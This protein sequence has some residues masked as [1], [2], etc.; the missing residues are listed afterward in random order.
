MRFAPRF[1]ARVQYVGRGSP[2]LDRGFAVGE[3]DRVVK[4]HAHVEAERLEGPAA[5]GGWEMQVLVA[6]AIVTRILISATE[7]DALV[8]VIFG[9]RVNQRGL[10]AIDGPGGDG[11][12]VTARSIVRENRG[13]AVVFEGAWDRAISDE[14]GK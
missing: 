10:R 2:N 12:E 1:L 4:G 5:S 6:A 3:S 8:V 9:R 7:V 13:I 14:R 11:L